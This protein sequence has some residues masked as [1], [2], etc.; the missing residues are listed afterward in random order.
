MS[1]N[2]YAWFKSKPA[3]LMRQRKEHTHTYTQRHAQTHTDSHTQTEIYRRA[4]LSLFCSKCTW[5]GL[6]RTVYAHRIWPHVWRFLCL[7]Y[8]VYTVYVYMYG[9]GQPYTR[10]IKAEGHWQP[11]GSQAEAH[12]FQHLAPLRLSQY[13][14][15]STPPPQASETTGHYSCFERRSLR[16]VTKLYVQ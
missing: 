12:P 6:A 11:V 4:S 5:I 8:R 14:S 2:A 16:L 3:M 7:K 9:P 10:T 13:R 15:T 1:R